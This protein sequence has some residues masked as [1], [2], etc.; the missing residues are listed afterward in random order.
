MIRLV[1][2]N[3]P[4]V[5]SENEE[6]WTQ[7]YLRLLAGDD[8]PA[9]ARYRY[10]NSEI[11]AVLRASSHHKCMYCESKIT[12]VAL[13][14]V[15]HIRPKSKAPEL[16][17]DWDNLGLVCAECNR[18]KLDYDDLVTPLLN[19]YVDDPQQDLRFYGPTVHHRV[20][21]VRGEVTV[22]TLKLSART[23]LFERRKERIEWL[24]TLL[25]R[26]QETDA[27]ALKVVL[28]EQLTLELADSA[29][30]AATSRAFVRAARS[31]D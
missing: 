8:V 11:K 18:E 16:V 25:D 27:P 21:S 15:E 1:R 28:E 2:G 24:Q 26:I 5:L 14:D 12:H 4:P 9:A 17:V 29:E 20:G 3:K 19:P 7:E 23:A 22:R 31:P 30:Y 6:R 13:G 10:R